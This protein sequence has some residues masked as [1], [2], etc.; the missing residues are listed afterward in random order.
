MTCRARTSSAPLSPAARA[1][2]PGAA[3][4]TPAEEAMAGVALCGRV[5]AW[6]AHTRDSATL[7]SADLKNRVWG[8]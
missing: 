6:A 4:E 2:H 7:P 5:A 3:V 8:D 1:A